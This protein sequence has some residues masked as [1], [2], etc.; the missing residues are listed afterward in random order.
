MLRI[1]LVTEVTVCFIR[2]NDWMFSTDEGR[3]ELVQSTDYQRLLVV[4]LSR[5]HAYASVDDVKAELSTKV[6]ELAPP[7]TKESTVSIT[8]GTSSRVSV[9]WNYF[10]LKIFAKMLG[11]LDE[12]IFVICDVFFAIS[13]IR[14]S[15]Q[16]SSVANQFQS[17]VSVIVYDGCDIWLSR[18]V[19]H[20]ST[21]RYKLHVY[22]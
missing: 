1:Y 14:K 9:D 16:K 15:S 22:T 2:E 8:L 3:K 19:W 17:T 13:S 20:H 11:N 12:K 7:E 18:N 21:S 10:T 4:T 6:M 5:G